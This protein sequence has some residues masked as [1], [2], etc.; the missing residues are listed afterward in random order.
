MSKIVGQTL[1]FIE[2]FAAEKRPLS[3]SE[4]SRLL[5]LAP[6]SCHDVMV[7]LK[8]RGYIYELKPR[9]GY[10]PTLRL[11]EVA[12][13]IAD[14]DP[15]VSRAA[16]LLR[17]TRDSI[18]ES[19]LLAKA[20]GLQATYLLAFDPAS[21]L[22][23]RRSV[24]ENILGL[25][26]TSAG[27]ALLG[28]LTEQELSTFLESAVLNQATPMTITSKTKLR[29]EIEA[30]NTRGWFLNREENQIGVT[31][32]S[33]RFYWLSTLFIVT[34]AGP[35]QRVEPRLDEFAEILMKIGRQLSMPD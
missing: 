15:V 7:E 19:V 33:V 32:V 10:Y 22:A 34:I 6:S 20:T 16:V 1:D 14:H 30:G 17:E 23:V 29:A 3:L 31:T 4:I 25:H 12:K 5:E 11:F 9:G 28:S 13:A 8:V 27:K 24:G 26:L 18:G 21:P 35:S 2:L